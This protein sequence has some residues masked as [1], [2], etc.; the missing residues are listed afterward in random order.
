MGIENSYLSFSLTWTKT[1]IAIVSAAKVILT[2][3]WRKG[4]ENF[5]ASING[6]W[7]EIA[8]I[9]TRVNSSK[10]SYPMPIWY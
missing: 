7:V 3:L 1:Q 5:I 4:Q 2:I 9:L 8:D 6:G 10:T